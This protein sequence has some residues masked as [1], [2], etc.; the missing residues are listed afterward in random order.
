MKVDS[1][2]L[3]APPRETASST[4]IEPPRTQ[5][6]NKLWN[7]QRSVGYISDEAIKAI[8]A[9]FGCADV[10]VEGVVSFYHLLRPVSG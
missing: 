8:A 7:L 2:L 5:L 4:F 6:L 10:E 3:Q 1:P 9:E